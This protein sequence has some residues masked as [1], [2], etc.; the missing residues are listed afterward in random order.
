MHYLRFVPTRPEECGM[1]WL[2]RRKDFD[3][4]KWRAPCKCQHSHEEHNPN[5]PYKC[6]LC[7]KCFSFS[8]Y[9]AC[10][11]CDQ[12]WENHETIFETEKERIQAKK[13]IGSAFLPLSQNP[14]I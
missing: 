5:P 10:I 6:T 13:T 4:T 11:S 1:Y 14:D 9:F 12:T 3:V 7:A 2:P 8:S